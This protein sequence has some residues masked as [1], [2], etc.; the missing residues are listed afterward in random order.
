MT[1]W[2]TIWA[3][4][5]RNV[6]IKIFFIKKTSIST[7]NKFIWKGIIKYSKQNYFIFFR[8][9][10]ILISKKMKLSSI[11]VEEN[12][13][14]NNLKNNFFTAVHKDF[15]I[16]I[17]TTFL[18]TYMIGIVFSFPISTW[19]INKITKRKENCLSQQGN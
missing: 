1:P 19:K 18:S 5:T 17:L 13:L 15:L 8:F 16:T 9:I 2:K 7:I 11:L 4:K 3:K 14:L 6:I 10:L 12:I